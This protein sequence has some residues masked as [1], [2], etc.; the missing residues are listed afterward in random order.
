MCV[1]H[2][3][4]SGGQ[5]RL[6]FFSWTR[7]DLVCVCNLKYKNSHK[8]QVCIYTVIS[9]L[10]EECIIIWKAKKWEVKK[11]ISEENESQVRRIEISRQDG[12]PDVWPEPCASCRWG[13]VRWSE[14]SWGGMG[15]Q[16][17][18]HTGPW[19]TFKNFLHT[20][21][22]KVNWCS[23]CEKHYGCFP[24]KIK[25]GTTIWSS[26][27]TS[28]CRSKKIETS[29]EKR[30]LHPTFNVALF[31]KIRKPPKCPLMNG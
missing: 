13:E 11:G 25:N 31:T 6:S 30:Y 21:G 9:T 19:G 24:Q 4:W 16:V 27:L 10:K 14:I 18:D 1:T 5:C 20:F 26:N 12:G 8:T 28:V 17:S 7:M 23:H 2:W 22:R 15:R 29:I 3:L